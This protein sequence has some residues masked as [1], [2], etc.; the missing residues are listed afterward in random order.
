MT[1]PL[2]RRRFL[3]LGGAA[4]GASAL[5]G[6]H[7]WAKPLLFT[8]TQPDFSRPVSAHHDVVI[9]GGGVSGLTAAYTLKKK[10]HHNVRVLEVRDRVGGRTLNAPTANGGYVELGGQWIG[11]TQDEVMRLMGDLGIGKFPTYN[12]GRAVDDTSGS[13]SALEYL[14]YLNAIRRINN[15]SR[16][17]PLS[18]PWNAPQAAAWDAMTVKDWMDQNMQFD[19]G[20]ELIE[21][22]VQTDFGGS[23]R[24]VSLLWFLFY[25]H[26]GTDFEHMSD[27]AQRW[28]IEGG[29]QTIALELANRLHNQVQLDAGVDGI[30]WTDRGA[31]VHYGGQHV[32]AAKKVIIAMMPK[33]MDRMNFF[34]QLPVQR[35]QLQ[36]N[37]STGGGDKYFATYAT[38]FWRNQGL[39]GVAYSDNQFIALAWDNTPSTENVGVLGGFGVVEGENRPPSR[40]LRKNLVLRAFADFFGPQA[41]NPLAFHEKSWGLDP[42]TE[43]CVT[44]LAPGLLTSYGPAIREPVG[45][46]HWAGTE[47]STV[48]CG[49]ID[50]AVRAGKRAAK[51]VAA[52]I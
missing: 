26:S 46:I 5:G 38:P 27:K 51:E 43:G 7:A 31:L 10:G 49:Y 19:A 3:Q 16:Q 33:D 15:L 40:R 52:L 48:W 1:S 21:I 37:W 42:L 29:S 30:L 20:K 14:D 28:R 4:L 39:S 24:E 50:G 2:D 12:T 8:P 23:A 11:P 6:P 17:V 18:D 34:P 41:L 44:P 36:R 35:D 25:V 13:I 45:P 9:I 22:T 47:T 32:I